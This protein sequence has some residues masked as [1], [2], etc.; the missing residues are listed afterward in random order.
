MGRR[1]KGGRGAHLSGVVIVDK[2]QG[3][4]SHDVVGRIRRALDTG[5]VGHAGTLDPM[6][7]GVLVIAV[8]EGTKLVPYLTA[9]DK[10]YRATLSIGVATDS[11]DAEGERVGE[12]PLLAVDQAEVQRVADGFLG[13][14]LQRAPKVSAIKVDGERLHAKARRGDDFE[15]PEREVTLHSVQILEVA[16][17]RVELELRAAK[18]FYVRSFGRDLAAALG[19]VGHLSML[20]RTASGAFDVDRAVALE[21]VGPDS[22]MGLT[23]AAGCVM[24]AVAVDEA[25][26]LALGQGKTIEALEEGPALAA[27]VHQDRLV[28]IGA[29]EGAQ[30]RVARGFPPAKG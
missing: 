11:L 26:A 25:Q 6:A 14:H 28:A 16:P 21:D 24:D 4:T 17:D 9:A 15:A 18:G 8:G 12:G 2:P 10:A 20:R 30:W 5:R 22:L 1:R 29:R 23:E 19:T 27:L 7:T 13:P 3:P